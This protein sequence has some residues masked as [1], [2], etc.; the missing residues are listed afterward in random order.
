MFYTNYSSDGQSDQHYF[1]VGIFVPAGGISE[2][3]KILEFSMR[4][5][6]YVKGKKETLHTTEACTF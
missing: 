5:T 4:R 1:G 3:R 2:L 6:S